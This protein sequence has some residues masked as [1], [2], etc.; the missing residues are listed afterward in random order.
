MATPAEHLDATFE[1]WA[2]AREPELQRTAHLLTGEL[3]T[4]RAHVESALAVVLGAGPLD[5]AELDPL[6]LRA[7]IAEIA[8][9]RAPA[10]AD[11]VPTGVEVTLDRDDALPQ[12][13]RHPL[14]WDFLATLAPAHR[15]ALVLRLHRG[16]DDEEIAELVGSTPTAVADEVTTALHDLAALL[17]L[18]PD[19]AGALAATTLCARADDTAVSPTPIESVREVTRRRRTRRTRGG[20]LLAAAALVVVGVPVAALSGGGLPAPPAPVDTTPG[21]DPDFGPGDRVPPP[22]VLPPGSQVFRQDLETRCSNPED[23]EFR[24]TTTIR[25]GCRTVVK[26]DK[27]SSRDSP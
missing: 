17:E 1:R 9:G 6:A 27:D 19:A 3:A 25:S 24:S 22:W 21:E 14:V 16:L 7:L 23:E 12:D 18:T 15:A 4:A 5:E 2:D 10:A 13:A 26:R 11:A 20:L 8:S